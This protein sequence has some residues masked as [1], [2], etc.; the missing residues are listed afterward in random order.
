MTQSEQ[1]KCQNLADEI[2]DEVQISQALY[3]AIATTEREI[4]VP[5]SAH[6]YS[7]NA[8]PIE[9]GQ[10]ISSPLSVAKMT[11]A[12]ECEDVDN[13]LEVGCGSGYQAAILSKLAHRVFSVERIQKLATEAKKRFESL[14]VKNVHV[15]FDDGNLGWA[16]YAPYERIILSCGCESVPDRLFSQLKVGGILVAPVGKANQQNIVKFTKLADGD[17]KEEIF[18]ECLFVPLLAGTE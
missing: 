12:L 13:V 4:F 9:G 5:I 10:W 8:H 1:I 18:D 11:K 7:V 2:A 3:N 6:A 14:G 15:R 17:I 16:K